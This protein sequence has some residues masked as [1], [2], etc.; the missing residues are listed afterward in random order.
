MI[1]MAMTLL[2]SSSAS[3][4]AIPLNAKLSLERNLHRLGIPTGKVDG[5]YDGQTQRAMCIWRELTGR[6]KSRALPKGTDYIDVADTENLFPTTQQHLGLNINLTCQAAYWLREDEANPIEI[7]KASTGRA[8]FPT[9]PGDYK[10]RWT[11]D[12]WYESKQF[13]DGWMYRPMFFNEG[14][15]LHGSQTDSMVH[16]YPASHGCVRMLHK[17]IDFLWREGFGTGSIVHVYGRWT[18]NQ[19]S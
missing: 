15:A 7:F 17:D 5:I 10:V 13:P 18:F 9:D 6:G 2:I 3:A 19:K 11:I 4:Q 16:S 14:Q 8:E 1:A 12:R